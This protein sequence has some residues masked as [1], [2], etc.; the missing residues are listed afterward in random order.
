MVAFTRKYSIHIFGQTWFLRFFIYERISKSKR[1]KRMKRRKGET[2]EEIAALEDC[3][4]RS[5]D[6]NAAIACYSNVR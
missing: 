4:G 2:Y 1:G 3:A 6:S 5:N